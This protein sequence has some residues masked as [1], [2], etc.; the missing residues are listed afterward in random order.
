MINN[1]DGKCPPSC[2]LCARDEGVN[3]TEID[4]TYPEDYI[5]DEMDE[6]L[7]EEDKDFED[8]LKGTILESE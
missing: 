7:R 5:D 1:N 4:A 3:D 8:A 2:Q 6:S